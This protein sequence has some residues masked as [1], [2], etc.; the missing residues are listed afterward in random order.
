MRYVKN[1]AKEMFEMKL[2]FI[3]KAF[4][5]FLFAVSLFVCPCNIA[6]AATVHLPEE[7]NQTAVCIEAQNLDI[8]NSLVETDRTTTVT[9]E[10]DLVITETEISYGR[11]PGAGF[12]AASTMAKS[13]Y[14]YDWKSKTTDIATG[15]GKM[16]LR[17][18]QFAEFQ[19]NGSYVYVSDKS[20][21]YY[22]Y[23]T[24]SS[25]FVNSSE[26]YTSSSNKSSKKAKYVVAGDLKW[27]TDSGTHK[28]HWTFKITCSP[29][30]SISTSA[31]KS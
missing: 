31:K 29:S 25:K 13:S 18:V 21:V 20:C 26:S 23:S 15:S 5:S 9:Y 10:D 2:K 3:C 17:V 12:S 28:S 8:V 7:S 24:F 4:L 22:T 16:L 19:F 11:L 6:S 27:T 14:T 1:Q 30:G